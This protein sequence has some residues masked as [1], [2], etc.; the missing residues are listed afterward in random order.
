MARMY[1]FFNLINL[2]KIVD[3]CACMC[4]FKMMKIGSETAI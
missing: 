3:D 1:N 2:I 4:F